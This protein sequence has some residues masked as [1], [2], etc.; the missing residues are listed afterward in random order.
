MIEKFQPSDL[1]SVMQIWLEDNLE[2]HSFVAKDYFLSHVD[3]VK[4]AM[5]KANIYVLKQDGV[6]KAFIGLEDHN[7]AGLFVDKKYQDQ[8][9]GKQLL[10]FVKLRHQN[11]T[12]NVFNKNKRALKF[13]LREGFV[14]IKEDLDE[15]TEELDLTLSWSKN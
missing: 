2:V 15:E 11:L 9:L 5:L 4:A 12:L 14:L 1:N 8:G 7:I 10:D 3:E 13:Y 6:I